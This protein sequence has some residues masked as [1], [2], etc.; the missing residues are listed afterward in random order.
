VSGLKLGGGRVVAPWCL[1][2]QACR[3]ARILETV[4]IAAAGCPVAD[5]PSSSVDCFDV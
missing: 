4:E 3:H 2:K 1:A 5:A